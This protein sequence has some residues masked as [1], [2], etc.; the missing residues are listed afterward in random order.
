[1]E[2]TRRVHVLIISTIEM[3][4]ALEERIN[5]L[6]S[7]QSRRELS[8]SSDQN[9]CGWATCYSG[10]LPQA[11]NTCLA[12][13]TTNYTHYQEYTLKSRVARYMK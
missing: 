8:L 13:R 7:R 12:C 1:M 10:I 2:E 6:E 4:P 5:T 9:P 3:R 11:L